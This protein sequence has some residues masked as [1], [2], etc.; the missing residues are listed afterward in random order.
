MSGAGLVS[1]TP[2]LCAQISS[3]DP[4]A[5]ALCDDLGLVLTAGNF[6]ALPEL[7]D[8]TLPPPGQFPETPTF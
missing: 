4:V 5:Q 2:P 3:G 6:V 7:S 8:V 1:I